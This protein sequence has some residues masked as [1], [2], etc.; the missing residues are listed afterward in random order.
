MRLCCVGI[1]GSAVRC[2][3]LLSVCFFPQAIQRFTGPSDGCDHRQA[4][5]ES[6]RPINQRI[7]SIC[8]HEFS[9]NRRYCDGVVAEAEAAM[10]Y[11][12]FGPLAWIFDGETPTGRGRYDG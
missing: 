12:I 4:L 3:I 1:R 5:P 2:D 6:D 10:I 7:K 8:N 9:R 11:T